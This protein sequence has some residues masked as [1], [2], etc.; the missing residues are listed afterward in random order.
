MWSG[1]RVHLIE[2]VH[3][4]HI[5]CARLMTALPHAHV[6]LFERIVDLLTHRVLQYILVLRLPAGERFKQF[7]FLHSLRHVG[8]TARFPHST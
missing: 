6:A 1:V 7:D 3:N 8:T 2:I 4:V 5:E